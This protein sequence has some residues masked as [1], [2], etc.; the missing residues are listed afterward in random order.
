M[1][2]HRHT[3]RLPLALVEQIRELAVLHDRSLSAELSVALAYVQTVAEQPLNC[4]IKL[5]V[6]DGTSVTTV[7][8][9]GREIARDLG[10]NGLA[11]YLTA[12]DG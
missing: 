9:F 11:V 10:R 6:A 12:T 5:D 1:I 2:A 7:R 8:L 3:V 4:E